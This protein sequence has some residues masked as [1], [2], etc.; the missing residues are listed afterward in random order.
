MLEVWQQFGISNVIRNHS[1]PG[2][3]I[4]IFRFEQNKY[5]N[6]TASISR[7]VQL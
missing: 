6:N 1:F 7:K 2:K 3:V 4:N 5:K